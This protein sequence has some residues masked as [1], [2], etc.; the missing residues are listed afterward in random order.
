MTRNKTYRIVLTADRTLMSE[1]QREIFF[2]F[3]ACIPQTL[4]PERL[5][6][7]L[8]CPPI[9]V[10]KDGAPEVAPYGIRKIEAALIDYGFGENDVLV[11]HPDHLEKVIGPQTKVVGITETDPMGNGPASS[12]FTEI[13]GGE[14]YMAKKFREL[15]NSPG[16]KNYKPKIIVGGSGSWH[17]ADEK[18]RKELGIDTLVLGEGEKVAGP[19]FE[20]AVTGEDL[21]GIV[22]GDPI[23][24][25]EMPIIRR[26][27]VMGI[28]EIARGCGCGCDFCLPS[29]QRFR[30]RSVEHI[31]EEVETNLKAGRQPLLHAEDVFRYKSNGFKVNKSAVIDL[32]KKVKNHPGVR[33][34]TFSHFSLASVTSSPGLISEISRILEASPSHWLSGQTGIETG[35]PKLMKLHMRGKTKPFLPDDWPHVVHEAFQILAEHHWIP[36]ATLILGLPGETEKDINLT[37]SLLEKLKPYKSLIIPLFFVAGGRIE[38]QSES[39]RLNEMTPKHTELFVRSWNHNL[40]WSD[41]LYRDW[42]QK[43]NTHPVVKRALE[44]VISLSMKRGKK[45][46]EICERDYKYDLHRMYADRKR[47][48]LKLTPFSILLGRLG[49]GEKGLIS[50]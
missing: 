4:M 14:A 22:Y 47:G 15:L 9:K 11:A 28:V 10:N 6:F 42:A 30:C 23:E 7:S 46:L 50:S 39:F 36:C 13:F 19:L 48:A 29:F 20:K 26:A 24:E 33:R 32:V 21:P 3:S 5:Y 49:L 31:L 35:S 1:Y 44:F 17:L 25:W 37:L 18:V 27:T 38:H 41:S 8:F 2:G 40:E 34:I 43:K 12:T 16:L 45:L